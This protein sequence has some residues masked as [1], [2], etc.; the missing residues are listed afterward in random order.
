MVSYEAHA[1]GLLPPTLRW[2]TAAPAVTQEN[3]YFPATPLYHDK[4][5]PEAA[6]LGIPTALT[7]GDT[8]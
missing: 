6:P 4:I 8:R 3:A 2:S 1:I 5:E 7:H